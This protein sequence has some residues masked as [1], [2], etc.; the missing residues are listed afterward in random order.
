MLKYILPDLERGIGI[1]QNQAH[2]YDVYEHN[3][4]AMQHA[5]DKEWLL[6]LRIAALLHDISKPETRVWS[7]EK[8]RLDL[9]WPRGRGGQGQQEDT[10]RS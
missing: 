2:S 4:R 6:P 1:D 9:S 8:E 3:M 5:A 10:D 7:E